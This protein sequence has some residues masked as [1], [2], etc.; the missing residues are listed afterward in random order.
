MS[1]TRKELKTLVLKELV[2]ESGDR[3]G[4]QKVLQGG[5]AFA[6]P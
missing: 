1:Q 3:E 2:L 4:F 5:G 6:K